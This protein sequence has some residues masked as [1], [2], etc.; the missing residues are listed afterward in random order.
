MG[1][2]IDEGDY[3]SMGQCRFLEL[4]RSKAKEWRERKMI[5]LK[6]EWKEGLTR[7]V[8]IQ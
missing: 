8:L 3:E 4:G 5:D 1:W 7:T 6:K 2:E